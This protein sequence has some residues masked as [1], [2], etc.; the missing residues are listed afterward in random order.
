MKGLLRI[1]GI[2]V[3]IGIGIVIFRAIRQYR[4]DSVFDLAPAAAGG[5][6]GDGQKR[7]IS[8]ELLSI[9]ADPADKGPVELISD[10]DGKEWLINRRNGFRYPV[11][12]GIPIM[13]VEEGEKNKD[14]GLIQ[15]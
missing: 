13:L 1:V 11:E 3:L 2:A 12:D 14:E 4:E 8:A 6:G 15:K 5:A 10:G 9:L 7:S